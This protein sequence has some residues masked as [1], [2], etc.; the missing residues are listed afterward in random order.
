MAEQVEYDMSYDEVLELLGPT[1]DIGS[2]TIVQEYM[3]SD[4]GTAYF[5]YTIYPDN[6]FRV[7]HIRIVDPGESC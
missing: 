1:G 3:L 7:T 5:S 2:G 4:G 6:V